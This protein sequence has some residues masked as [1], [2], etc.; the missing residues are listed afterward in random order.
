MK[1]LFGT[2]GIRAVAGTPPLDAPSVRKFGLALAEVLE[3]ELGR[4]PRVVCGR[5]T[6]ESGPWLRDAVADGLAARGGQVVDAGVI[7]TPGLAHATHTAP[8]DAGV[9]ISA[10]HNPFEDNGLKVFSRDGMKLE[11]AME[12]RIE[13]I[14]LDAAVPFP[15]ERTGRAVLDESLVAKYVKVLEG[16]V[17]RGRLAGMRLLLDC[18]NGAA[19]AIAPAVFRDL[20]ATVETQGD[21]PNGRNI[22]L[23]CGSLHLDGLASRVREGRFDVGLAFDGDADRCLAVDRGGRIIDGDHI[24]FLCALRLKRRGSLAGDSVVATI[25]SNFWLEQRLR[26]EGIRLHRAPVGDKYVLERMLVENAMLGGE[27]SGHVIFRGI[28]TTGD[29]ILTGLLLLDAVLDEPV[30]LEATIDGIVPFPQVLINVRVNDKPDLRAHPAIG[31]VVADAER[32]V[33]G[34]GRVVLR[35]SGTEKLARVMVEADDDV[36]VQHTAERVAAVI[37]THLGE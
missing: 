25:M 31:P 8:F 10:S 14:I 28:G 2:D 26:E 9:M 1:R 11:D 19:S 35:Y 24:L 3:H 37:R 33:E 27:Q 4:P 16:A 7:T 22:N 21:R 34:R 18:A 12:S 6:R 29:G 5:D 30:S 36:L 13:A 20:G 15:P 32:A 23:G 17:P